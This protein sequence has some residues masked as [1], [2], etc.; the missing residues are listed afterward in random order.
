M[1]KRKEE[2]IFNYDGEVD[3]EAMREERVFFGKV[4]PVEFVAPGAE[5][6]WR[7]RN[8]VDIHWS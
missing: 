3:V 1:G 2:L 6:K 5:Q 7:A 8:L 4:T